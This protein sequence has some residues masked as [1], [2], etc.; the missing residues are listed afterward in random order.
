MHTLEIEART[1]AAQ[2]TVVRRAVIPVE[3]L[4]EWIA[5]TLREL[6]DDLRCR[7]VVPVGFPFA[8]HHLEGDGLLA[9]EA[10][11]P[12]ST[13]ASCAGLGIRSELPAGPVAIARYDGPYEKLPAARSNILEWLRRHGEGPSG[14]VWEIYHAPPIGDPDTWRVEL[15]QPFRLT[16][17]IPHTP[18]SC[19][20]IL[21]A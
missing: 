20:D 19:L 2:P 17:P 13:P 4:T 3:H 5:T 11:F 18:G 15:V 21:P 6:A 14:D 9:V 16:C 8:R 1:I 7:D 12:I 10:G